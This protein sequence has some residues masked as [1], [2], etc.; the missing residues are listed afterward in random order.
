MG[1]KIENNAASTLAA[2]I[3]TSDTSISLASGGGSLFP[4]LG[5]GDYFWATLTHRL[6]CPRR[7]SGE[8]VFNKR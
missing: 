8:S 1:I 7:N 2:G 6:A 5:A 4:T 3:G